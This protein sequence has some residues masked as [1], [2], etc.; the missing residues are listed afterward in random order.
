LFGFSWDVID[1]SAG[2]EVSALQGFEAYALAA[3]W[4]MLAM[5]AVIMSLVIFLEKP[6]ELI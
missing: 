6:K 3:W 1:I 2:V 5:V 4:F